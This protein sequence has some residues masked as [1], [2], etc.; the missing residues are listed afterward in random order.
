MRQPGAGARG[1]RVEE[2]EGDAAGGGGGDHV[3]PEVGLDEGGERGLPVVEE[4]GS[5]VRR[6]GGEELVDDAGD[7]RT[8]HRRAAGGGGGGDK[9]RGVGAGGGEVGHEVSGRQEF[10]DG[11]GVEPED[12][13]GRAGTV[14]CPWRS[15]SRAGSAP[16][17]AWARSAGRSTRPGAS[18]VTPR[19][20]RRSVVIRPYGSCGG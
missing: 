2:C 17:P 13:A 8:G 3:G 6:V 19:Q 9:E 4:A 5:G 11:G 1:A 20:S 12:R 7:G 14:A 18:D 16:C 15:G 10:A